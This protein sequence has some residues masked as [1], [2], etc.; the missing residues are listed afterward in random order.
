MISLHL[1]RFLLVG[2]FSMT[3]FCLF[4]YQGIEIIHSFIDIFR[5]H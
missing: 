3:A 2:F 1:I 5:R 4:A